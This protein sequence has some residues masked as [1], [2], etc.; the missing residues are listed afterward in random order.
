MTATALVRIALLGLYKSFHA[1]DVAGFPA[2]EADAIIRAGKGRLDGVAPAG[3]A[4]PSDAFDGLSR[5]EMILY[6]RDVFEVTQ[7][8]PADATDE[9]LRAALRA[10][11]VEHRAADFQ[12]GPARLDHPTQSAQVDGEVTVRGVGT[13]NA[14]PRRDTPKRLTVPV[15]PAGDQLDAMDRLHLEALAMTKLGVPAIDPELTDDELRGQ[16]RTL[17]AAKVEAD[18][19]GADKAAA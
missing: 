4:V 15:S 10:L 1:G 13:E 7:D 2:Y 6:A 18:A 17:A 19:K 11:A 9:D 3:V 12:E 5:A 8:P 14:V 16:I